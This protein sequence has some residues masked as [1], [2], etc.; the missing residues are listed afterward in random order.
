MLDHYKISDLLVSVTANNASNNSTL[1]LRIE[2]VLGGQF[3]ASDHMLG[4]M[5]HVINLAAKDGLAAFGL[6]AEETKDKTNEDE[7]AG[8][9]RMQMDH[10]T[11]QPNGSQINIKTII[12]RIH[13]LT[14]Y[15]R[16]TPQQREQF[17]SIMTLVES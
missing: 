3:F 8:S 2:E 9:N 13:G 7:T 17:K 15:V 4:C 5:A 10:I 14:T 12:T 11:S 16:A 1:A 6:N